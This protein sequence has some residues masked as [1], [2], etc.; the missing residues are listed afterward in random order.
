MYCNE[1]K[2]F[3]QEQEQKLI[4]AL[5]D[6]REHP[7]PD[8]ETR[9]RDN[10]QRDY[11]RIL[12][13]SSFRRL[14]GKMQLFEIDPE[15]F[16]RNR[17]T[18]SLEVA[19]I[20]RSIASDLKLVNP[21]VVELAALT[22]DIGNPPFGHSGEKLLNELSEEIGGYEGNAQ[23]LR[24]L[25]KLEKKFSYC[26]GLN[27]TH[28]SLLSVVKYPAPRTANTAGKF[29]YDD[30]FDFY[31][32]L[33]AEN[34]LDLN[35]GEKTIDAQIMDLADEIAYAAH[36]LED[37]LSRNM[38]TIEDIEYEFQ[39]SDEFRGAREQFREIV[40]Q[41]RNTAFQ[42][43]LLKTSEEFAIIFRKELTS[44]IVNRLVADI[45]V[46]T[47]LNG[48]QELGFGKL[49][50]LSEGLKKLLFKVIMRKRNI[51]TYEFRGNKIIRDLYD[52]YNEGENYKFLPP[53]LKFTLP[54]P[55][56]CIFEIS[57][58]RAVVDYISG[59][60]DTFAVKEWETHCLK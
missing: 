45:S 31:T 19:Q 21:V 39:I 36:D 22:H 51:L 33:L 50:A 25:R 43:N 14:Q 49:N 11:A 9:S 10:Y 55:D 1:L 44:N 18:H 15:K 3:A 52:F 34:Q 23:A 53:E 5:A 16:N 26:N 35:P 37:A 17:L 56:S 6:T 58:K 7:S 29:I 8:G 4:S 40:T 30:D 54:Q 32:N 28:R 47:N 38:V 46:V 59:M 60:M 2:E 57:K 41:S 48:F 27:L 20:A 24:I 12:Y 13:S 42:A